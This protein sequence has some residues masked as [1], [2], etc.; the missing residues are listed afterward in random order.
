M[1]NNDLVSI[2]KSAKASGNQGLFNNS[3]QVWNHTFY[4]LSM[5][6]GGGGEPTGKLAEMINSSFGS[7]AEF[8][9]A[10]ETAGN[11]QFGSGWAWLLWTAEGLKIT[12]TG[13]A[14]TPVTDA[15]VVP[16][17]CMDVWEHAYYLDY[18]NARPNYT[19]CFTTNLVNWDFAAANLPR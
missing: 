14:D 5:K 9:T 16:L 19:S 6:Q 3:A 7:Y 18:Q 10:F 13:N 12:K 8:K 15:S 11:T 2:I 1:E 17:M 4:W